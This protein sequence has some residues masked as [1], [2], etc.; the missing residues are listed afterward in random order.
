MTL[1]RESG[2][3]NMRVI[4]PL[5]GIAL[6]LVGDRVYLAVQDA[7]QAT[8]IMELERRVDALERK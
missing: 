3:W 4:V 6:A 5:I 2:D 7:I 1:R 8:K